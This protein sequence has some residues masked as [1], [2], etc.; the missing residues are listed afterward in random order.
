LG[1]IIIYLSEGT[2]IR[3]FMSLSEIF[4][5]MFL[6]QNLLNSVLEINT[7]PIQTINIDMKDV[8]KLQSNQR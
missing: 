5:K 3:I 6:Q 7:E 2:A 1:R 8:I 4:F